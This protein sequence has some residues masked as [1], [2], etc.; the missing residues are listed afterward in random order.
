MGTYRESHVGADR[1]NIYDQRYQIG[2]EKFYWDSFEQPLLNMIFK[3]LRRSHPG[4][5]LDFAVGTGRIMQIAAPYFDD[6]VGVD[7]SNDMIVESRKKVP[8]AQFVVGDVTK[9][10]LDVGKFNVI[11]CF[12]FVLNAEPQLREDVLMWLRAVISDNGVLVINNHL[13]RSSATGLYCRLTNFV[14]NEQKHNLLSDIEI[15]EL[16]D[17]CDFKVDKRYGFGVVP[18]WRNRL[19]LP[20]GILKTVETML[21]NVPLLAHFAKDFIYICSPKQLP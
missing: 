16:L 13:N 20:R 14:R 8:T 6:V 15:K 4:R 12:R 1:G 21:M 3:D 10:N 7:I 18:V 11:T 5:Y 19:L 2:S 17:R 9:E